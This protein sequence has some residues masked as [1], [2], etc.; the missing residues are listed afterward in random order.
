ML[1]KLRKYA[2]VG[3][4]T[5]A[6]CAAVLGGM[7]LYNSPA[8][9]ERKRLVNLRNYFISSAVDSGVSLGDAKE[10]WRNGN[11][12]LDASD[13]DPYD[14]RVSMQGIS[15]LF[16]NP[17]TRNAV[18]TIEAREKKYGSKR[19][20]INHEKANEMI[21]GEYEQLPELKFDVAPR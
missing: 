5:F 6:A 17:T 12:L 21:R 4:G 10:I 18:F 16:R 11:I 3:V 7:L 15:D 2:L 13:K 14:G 8:E 19:E 9:Q 1:T 20:F